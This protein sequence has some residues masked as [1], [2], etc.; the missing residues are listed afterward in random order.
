MAEVDHELSHVD[1]PVVHAG[2][3]AGELGRRRRREIAQPEVV[4]LDA[5]I[6]TADPHRP[7]SELERPRAAG[8]DHGGRAIADGRQVVQSHRRAV[9]RRGEQLVDAAV[10]GDLRV[11]VGQRVASTARHDLG[12]VAF[13]GL[14]GVDQRIGLQTRDR[15]VI[16]AERRDGVRIGLQWEH[17]TRC[18]RRRLARADHERGLDVTEHQAVPR[19]VQRPRAV[20]L[21]VRL[22]DRRPGADPVDVRD[23]R[24]G[25]AR[26]VVAAPGD[27]ELDVVAVHA[28]ATEQ[29]VHAAHD[30]HLLGILEQPVRR[31]LRHRDD[32]NVVVGRNKAHHLVIPFAPQASLTMCSPSTNRDRRR[33]RRSAANVR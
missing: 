1:R 31:C 10:V 25:S 19:L 7:V 13:G 9:V 26:Q 3:L 22:I 6:E 24:E 12:E 23:E 14:A 20:H 29:V 32:G 11:R 16:E 30:H 27:G 17:V 2:L 4:R 5:M 21:D 8:D 28:R 15:G 18:A 33:L